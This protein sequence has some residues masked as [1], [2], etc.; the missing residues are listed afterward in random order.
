[1]EEIDRNLTVFKD[2]INEIE[3]AYGVYLLPKES[4]IIICDYDTDEEI[5]IFQCNN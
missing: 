4:S 5:G 3:D 1:M 2:D